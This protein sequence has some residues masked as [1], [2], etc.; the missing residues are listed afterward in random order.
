MDFMF[1]GIHVHQPLCRVLQPPKFRPFHTHMGLSFDVKGMPRGSRS[2][3]G[4]PNFETEPYGCLGTLSNF[5]C[6]EVEDRHGPGV[7]FE[8]GAS[9]LPRLREGSSLAGP[10]DG[11]SPDGLDGVCCWAPSELKYM[12]IYIYI[13]MTC[14]RVC[15]YIYIH[16]YIYILCIYIYI[17]TGQAQY[18]AGPDKPKL[19][20][21]RCGPSFGDTR[22]CWLF[23]VARLGWHSIGSFVGRQQKTDPGQVHC[24][25]SAAAFPR[26]PLE[27]LVV[28][29]WTHVLRVQT[30]D[31]KFGLWL[32][33]SALGSCKDGTLAADHRMSTEHFR[34]FSRLM[35]GPVGGQVGQS[36]KVASPRGS[37]YATSYSLSA[38]T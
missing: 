15:I 34:T 21:H 20:L 30:L 2:F 25:F 29:D 5:P 13:C 26:K 8:R 3:W 11:T 9:A 17:Y 1:K 27:N 6:P 12:Y 31:F 24:L 16:I 32:P 18:E 33:L 10:R 14:I 22:L 28:N 35:R 38:W 7:L 19:S 23:K 37:P 36:N 4:I